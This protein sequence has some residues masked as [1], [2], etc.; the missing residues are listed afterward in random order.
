MPISFFKFE[1]ENGHLSYPSSLELENQLS[2]LIMRMIRE[3]WVLQSLEFGLFQKYEI[4]N[5]SP[6][7]HLTCGLLVIKQ[8]REIR[9]EFL[10]VQTKRKTQKTHSQKKSCYTSDT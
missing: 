2:R 6:D 10:F 3:D 1:L 9:F 8:G 7:L 4:F 5:L